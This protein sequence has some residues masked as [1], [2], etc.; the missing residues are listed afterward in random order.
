MAFRFEI[1]QFGEFCPNCKMYDQKNRSRHSD[2]LFAYVIELLIKVL[3]KYPIMYIFRNM[4]H[5]RNYFKHLI[6]IPEKNM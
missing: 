6:H 4:K 5:V 2:T 3:E 1:Q